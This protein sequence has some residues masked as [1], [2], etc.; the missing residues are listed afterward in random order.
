MVCLGQGEEGVKTTPPSEFAEGLMFQTRGCGGRGVQRILGG[1]VKTT[2]PSEFAEGLRFETRG[3]GGR[4]VQR[5]LGCLGRFR[6]YPKTYFN[7]LLLG[8][9]K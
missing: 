4:G 6:G 7:I 8:L 2:P 3:F 5:I 9:E 1:G